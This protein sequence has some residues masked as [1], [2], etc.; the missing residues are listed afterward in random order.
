MHTLKPLLILVYLAWCGGL[1]VRKFDGQWR[2]YLTK[3]TELLITLL[4]WAL[5]EG[6]ISVFTG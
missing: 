1:N 4:F 3:P 6:I 5:M 2:A